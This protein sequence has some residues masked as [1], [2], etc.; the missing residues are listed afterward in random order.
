MSN[1]VD[2]DV[3][4]VGAGVS[5]VYA[6]WKLKQLRSDLNITVFEA[7]H[8]VGGRLL[9]VVPPGIP[10][11]VAELGGMRILP[12][13]QPRIATL[14]ETLNK[15][16][17]PE[18]LIETFAF[19]V[20]QPENISYLRGTHLR[21]K[22]FKYRPK[23]VPYKLAFLEFGKI[24]GELLLNAIEQI[25]PGI[26][27]SNLT[28]LQRRQMTQ[29]AEF[30]G[31]KLYKQGFWQVLVR[32]LSG[33]GYQLALDAGGYQSTLNNWNAADAIPWYLSD[34]GVDPVYRGFRKGFQQVPLTI[35][36]R[37]QELG[38]DLQL[39]KPVSHFEVAEDKSVR[40]HFKAHQEVVRAK[41]LILAMPRR[42]LDLLSDRS[43]FLRDLEVTRLIHSVTPQPL[44]KLFTTYRDPWWLP[45]G[46]QAG[47]TTTDLPVR[48]T[49][50]WPKNDGTSVTGGQAMLM[51]S[52][53]DG[54]N[55]GFWDGFRDKRGAG[56]REEARQVPKKERF[57]G[58]KE[59]TGRVEEVEEEWQ[60]HS[61]PA[62]MVE[63]VQRQ[64]RLIHGLGFVPNV[65]ESAFKDWGEDPYGGG[66][67]SWNIGVESW[68][69][70]QDIL[71]PVPSEQVY[72]CG[73][74]YSHAQ[75]WVEGALETA[76]LMLEKLETSPLFSRPA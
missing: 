24:P 21:L 74:A 47:R 32:V 61:A 68:Q 66:W 25:V 2:V 64:L 65:L 58:V 38:G 26:T 59:R 46:V 20:D 11:M 56:W 75:G 16:A 71:Q 36:K 9:S 49:Y 33:E 69:V 1:T 12:A 70:R 5:G 41:V 63:E 67:N 73:E 35:A 3:A 8:R 42:A 19:P 15:D 23:K 55:I 39:N 22:D 53:D 48:Q 6:G 14:L 17:R 43:P 57:V 76:D 4:I 52:Y 34:F 44:F 29:N 18:D 10:N 62:A 27:A 7:S 50:Y 31:E 45:A 37:F 72:I 30:A 40:L 60:R 54:L 28:E 51:A 13:V